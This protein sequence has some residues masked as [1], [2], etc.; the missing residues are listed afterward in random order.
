VDYILFSYLTT[1]SL[2]NE[3]GNE[4][5]LAKDLTS[6]LLPK[7]SFFTWYQIWNMPSLQL[8]RDISQADENWDLDSDTLG[9]TFNQYL[10]QKSGV[11]WL[12]T[13]PEVNIFTEKSSKMEQIMGEKYYLPHLENVLYPRYSGF[14]NCV[15]GLYKTTFNVLYDIS[16]VY[17][18][19]DESGNVIFEGPSLLAAFGLCE[20]DITVVV[21]VHSKLLTRIPLRR[22]K[23]EKWLERRWVKKDKQIKNLK[24]QISKSIERQ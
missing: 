9:S 8:W 24:E 7:L 5:M 3:F 11:Q 6:I 4:N 14:A 2:D 15:G 21:H 12:V 23:M 20:S 22:D 17:Y 18:Y 19:K 1:K 10:E 16:I 13:F